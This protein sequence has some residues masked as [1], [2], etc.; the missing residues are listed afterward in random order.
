MDKE[1]RQKLEIEYY[2]LID[3]IHKYD[4]YFINIKTWSISLGAVATGAGISLKSIYIPFLIILLEVAFWLTE[5]SFK[6]VQLSHF[7]RITELEN[8]LGQESEITEFPSPRIIQGY[9]ERRRENEESKL[10]RRVMWWKH[11]MFPH[12]VFVVT[13]VVGALIMTIQQLIK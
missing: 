10:W 11:V 5:A 1:L 4:E 13:G 7:K 3:I 9:S 8:V 12:V 2:H 6:V